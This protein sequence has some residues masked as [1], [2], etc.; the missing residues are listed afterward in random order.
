MLATDCYTYK[1]QCQNLMNEAQEL[2]LIFSAI[3]RSCD[4][5]NN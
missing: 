1:D 2:L 4:N 5:K 3:I